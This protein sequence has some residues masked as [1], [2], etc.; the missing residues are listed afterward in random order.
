MSNYEIP[1]LHD[2]QRGK[3]G[4]KRLL[5]CCGWGVE[6]EE[7]KGERKWTQNSQ[8]S[9]AQ[10]TPHEALIQKGTKRRPSWSGRGK[11]AAL[12]EAGWELGSVDLSHLHLLLISPEM[13]N[14]E[15]FLLLLISSHFPQPSCISFILVVVYQIDLSSNVLQ[16]FYTQHS[17]LILL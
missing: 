11:G 3:W 9:Q 17:S 1:C 4:K 14:P 16:H 15:A 8:V 7:N 6:G 2:P 12:G 10:K 13:I 5:D